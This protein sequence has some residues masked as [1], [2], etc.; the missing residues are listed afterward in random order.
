MTE[1]LSLLKKN[2]S[3]NVFVSEMK[4]CKGG[5]VQSAGDCTQIQCTVPSDCTQIQCTVP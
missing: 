2:G 1:I 5:N 4:N 3:P